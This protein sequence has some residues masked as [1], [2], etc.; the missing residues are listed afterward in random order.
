M[1]VQLTLQCQKPKVA[2][3]VYENRCGK[4][5]SATAV[6]FSNI[7]APKSTLQK[8]YLYSCLLQQV[9]CLGEVHRTNYSVNTLPLAWLLHLIQS[10]E[11]DN[12]EF[13]VRLCIKV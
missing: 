3:P 11:A 5:F 6:M 10:K 1:T 4:L 13:S 8:N 9:L 2:F 12:V 7:V